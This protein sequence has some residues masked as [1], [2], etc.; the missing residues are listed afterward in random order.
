MRVG[1]RTVKQRFIVSTFLCILTLLS[2]GFAVIYS[3]HHVTGQT[4]LARNFERQ[5]HFLQM[6]LRGLNEVVINEGTPESIRITKTGF[7]NF[8]SIHET[9]LQ[10]S[11]DPET[12]QIIDEKITPHWVIIK[13]NISPFFDYYLDIDRIES[14]MRAGKII[15]ETEAIIDVLNVL[16]KDSWN[17]IYANSKKSAQVLTIMCIVFITIILLSVL[18]AVHIYKNIARPMEALTAVAEKFSMGDMSTMMDESREDEFGVLAR[19]FNK[20]TLKLNQTTGELKQ[21][22]VQRMKAEKSIS[23][24]AYH[25]SLTGLPNRYLF[26]DRLNLHI[27]QV[28]RSKMK[29]GVVFLDVDDFKRIND[30][31][32]HDAGDLLLKEVAKKL[33]DCIRNTDTVYRQTGSTHENNTVARVGGDEFTILLTDMQDSQDAVI[34]AQRVMKALSEPFMLEEFE[35]FISL[36][37]GISVCPD[38]SEDSGDLLRNADV[39]MYHAKKQGKNNFKFYNQ[40]MNAVYHKRLEIENE[41]RK[42][43]ERDELLLH[44]QPRI[45]LHTGK[46]SSVEALVRWEKPGSGL[47]APAEFITVA[48]ETGLIIP[49]GEWVLK[50]A[51][52]QFKE[53]HTSGLM[54]QSISV[55]VSGK[56]IQ[57][58]DFI[59]TISHILSETSFD[60]RFLELEITESVLMKNVT[61]TIGILH[62]LKNMGIQLS[63]DDFGT[64]YSSFSYLKRFPLDIIKIDKLFINNI[65]E[66]ADD[67]AIVSAIISMVH[68]LRLKVVAE[69]VETIQQVDYLRH[70]ACD[71]AQGYYFSR[72]LPAPELKELLAVSLQQSLKPF[73]VGSSTITG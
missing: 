45:D 56:Q 46:I 36:S 65:T 61:N 42:A 2:I 58:E 4:T 70:K 68:H 37:M 32:G 59:T 52:T 30:T 24:I 29:L 44:Y 48:E 9:L 23:H 19:L 31:L 15:T 62:E 55:N 25:D 7:D 33:N 73:N 60:P 12:L 27:A 28:K 54:P 18:L 71:E 39:A 51:C 67:D 49:I 11:T 13:E 34:V 47:V 64:G 41:L 22:I 3:Y 38:D 50:T 5:S 53:W 8:Q 69:G 40:T 63:M 57:R 72:P 6:M 66:K 43:L 16:A 10:E 20:S 1:F 26:R 21:E 14:F 17:I 35:I